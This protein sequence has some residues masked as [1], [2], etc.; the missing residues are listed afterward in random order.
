MPNFCFRESSWQEQVCYQ[1]P[2]RFVHF[3]QSNRKYLMPKRSFST[4]FENPE[5]FTVKIISGKVQ[6]Q[7]INISGESHSGLGVLPFMPYLRLSV[8][9]NYRRLQICREHVGRLQ[10]NCRRFISLRVQKS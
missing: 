1:Y 10:P 7:Y 5:Q 6:V 9:S 8:L 4:T 3:N 2:Q